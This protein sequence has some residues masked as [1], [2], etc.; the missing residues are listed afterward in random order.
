MARET[1]RIALAPN[2]A[3]DEEANVT[4][5]KMVYQNPGA[6]K[7]PFS[8]LMVDLNW[9]GDTSWHIC[10]VS[11]VGTRE[12]HTCSLCHPFQSSCCPVAPA[13]QHWYPMG[14]VI[15]TQLLYKHILSI[16][17]TNFLIQQMDRWPAT[18]LHTIN[19]SY[20]QPPMT[21]TLKSIPSC[22]DHRYNRFGCIESL[23]C[24][25]FSS[26][27]YLRSITAA[28]CLSLSSENQYALTR[29][30]DDCHLA[31]KTCPNHS[32]PTHRCYE[33][34]SQSFIDVAHCLEHT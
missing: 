30:H 4:N 29:K 34:W 15:F 3:V 1:P 14:H 9:L 8:Q 13:P 7:S 10:Y 32:P 20:L 31:D 22:T 33:G 6:D 25:M 23:S 17:R 11:L 2:W 19:I 5:F 27:L 16:S 18:Y 21:Q 26:F 24:K 12:T 28:Q